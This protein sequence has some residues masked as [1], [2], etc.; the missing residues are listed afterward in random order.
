VYIHC[1][2]KP[3]SQPDP[4]RSDA[5]DDLVIQG[6]RIFRAGNSLAVRIPRAIAKRVGLEDGSAVELG[7]DQT[8]IYVR[9]AP[10][11]V[12]ADLIDR[13]TPLN[14]HGPIFD[15]LTGNERW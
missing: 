10:S 13:I 2:N 4:A 7:A 15:D 14:L 9:K 6:A 12:L 1:M 3:S 8:T 11:R 5:L